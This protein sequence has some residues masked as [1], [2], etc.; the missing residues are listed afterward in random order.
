MSLD[1]RLAFVALDVQAG[2]RE[3]GR[4]WRQGREDLSVRWTMLDASQRHALL[5]SVTAAA[6]T[7][8]EALRP[9]RNG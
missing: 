7:L 1:D 8:L 9:Q 3:L 6:V 4:L 2:V 5:M